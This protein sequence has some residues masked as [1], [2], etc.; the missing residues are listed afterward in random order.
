MVGEGLVPFRGSVGEGLVPFRGMVGEGLVPFRG[1]GH[2][3][4]GAGAI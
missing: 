4:G 3:R 2:G 1:S